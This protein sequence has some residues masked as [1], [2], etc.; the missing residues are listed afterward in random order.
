MQIS[1]FLYPLADPSGRPGY[2]VFFESDL[3]FFRSRQSSLDCRVHV[4]RPRMLLPYPRGYAERAWLDRSRRLPYARI[5]FFSPERVL[6]ANRTNRHPL[7]WFSLL[8]NIF[9]QPL[10]IAGGVIK[11]ARRSRSRTFR[12][13][14]AAAGDTLRSSRPGK[15]DWGSCR[16]RRPCLPRSDS[17]GNPVR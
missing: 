2:A 12:Y 7:S 11:T 10:A 14:W 3:T 9:Y 5:A 8:K 17:A 13:S 6:F 16:S 15:N 4:T 1:H